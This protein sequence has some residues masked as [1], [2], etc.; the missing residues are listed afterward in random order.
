MDKEIVYKVYCGCEYII[1]A[2]W[3]YIDERIE[4]D[5]I[6]IHKFC[7]THDPVKTIDPR[8]KEAIEEI[9]HR[10]DVWR[11]DKK[12]DSIFASEYLRGRAAGLDDALF[13]IEM[14]FPELKEDKD[15]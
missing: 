10:K 9:E 11:E 8:L 2:A 5:D 12:E 6:N 3:N 4:I 1:S 13:V 14:L 7:S 15:E